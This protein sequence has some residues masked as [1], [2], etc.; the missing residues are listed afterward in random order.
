MNRFLE[1]SIDGN[2]ALIQED[3]IS[4]IAVFNEK[5]NIFFIGGDSIIVDESLD[6]IRN[7][8]TKRKPSTRDSIDT[9]GVFY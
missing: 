2:I 5:T 4:Y 6:S 7:I 3:S 8:L 9:G 1:L